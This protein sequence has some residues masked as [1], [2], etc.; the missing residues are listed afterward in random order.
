MKILII[1][2]GYSGGGA[3]KVAR[4][5]FYGL[6]R[7]YKLH[8]FFIAG[9]TYEADP[10]V[11]FIYNYRKTALRLF[12]RTRNLFTNNARKRDSFS[13]NKILSFIKK[14]EIDV[15]HFHNIHGNY[16]GIEDISEISRCCKVVWTLHDMWLLTGHC[17]YAMHCNKWID[18][19]CKKCSDLHLYPQMFTDTANKIW[20]EKKKVFQNQ[21][22]TYVTP[23]RWLMDQCERTF[24]AD[25]QK[26]LIPNGVDTDTFYPLDSKKIREKY[27]IAKDK[28]VLLFAVNNINSPYKG[29]DILE[30]ALRSVQNTEN[31]ELLVVG[32]GSGYL[33]DSGYI[34]HY[35]GYINDDEQ[36]NELYNAADVFILPSRAENFP[37]SVLESMASGTPVI[38]SRAG[39]IVEQIDVQTG[40]LFDV[41]DSQQL[42]DIINRLWDEKDR[43]S[44]MGIQCRERVINLFG[45]DQM[46]RKYNELYT[47]LI[48]G[49]ST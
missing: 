36:M 43:F 21:N 13:R 2:S 48:K 45:E 27:Q 19:G 16:I 31:Y 10:P 12:N 38:G 44:D 35:M 18:A 37:C 26:Y 49:K 47:Y 5:L 8:T 40:W 11:Y 39:G 20:K 9:K 34:C 32:N 29:A 3:E 33:T 42:A 23:S 25:K 46:L 15:V 41:G 24:L 4:Q 28:I 30:N 6:Q 14:C 17:A 1:N 7:D 22:V